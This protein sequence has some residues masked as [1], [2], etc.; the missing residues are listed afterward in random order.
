MFEL[1]FISIVFA[2]PDEAKFSEPIIPPIPAPPSTLLELILP[3]LVVLDMVRPALDCKLP[4]MPPTLPEPITEE[5]FVQPE[6]VLVLW[7][8]SKPITPPVE[9][10]P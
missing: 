7:L 6:M 5:L 1:S 3:A 2:L 9:Q 4:I 8:L 10:V